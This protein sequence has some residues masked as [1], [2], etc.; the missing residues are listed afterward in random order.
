MKLTHTLTTALA[1]A[2]LIIPAAGAQ[3]QPADMHASTAIAAAQAQHKQD[4]RSADA[5]DAAI[6][7]RGPGHPVNAPG[8]TAV[9]SQSL[10]PAEKAPVPAAQPSDG[11]TDW[12]T[13]LIGIA[14]ALAAVGGI[15]LV[16]NRRHT[17]PR[18]GAS[19]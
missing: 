15:A 10:I 5:R 9:S 19:A 14:G 18:F 3:A 16:M 6:H 7:P 13:V 2:A 12:T 1:T 11:G 4:L 17:T 8:A